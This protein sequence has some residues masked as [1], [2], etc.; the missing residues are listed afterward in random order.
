MQVVPEGL[1]SPH[2]T[3]RFSL[4]RAII[5]LVF[6]QRAAYAGYHILFA[7]R[8]ELCQYGTNTLLTPVGVEQIG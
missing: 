3:K 2:T 1:D 4:I 7:V 5:R 6:V 8:M